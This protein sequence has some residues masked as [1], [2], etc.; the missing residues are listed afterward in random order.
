MRS[1]CYT[2][3]LPDIDI[4]NIANRCNIDFGNVTNLKT[5]TA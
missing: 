5:I 3:I 1:A 4:D 2:E